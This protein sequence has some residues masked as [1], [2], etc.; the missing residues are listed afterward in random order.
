M[1]RVHDRGAG[2]A[3]G[4][5]P[6]ASARFRVAVRVGAQLREGDG[7]RLCLTASWTPEAYYWANGAAIVFDTVAALHVHVNGF[8]RLIAHVTYP[9]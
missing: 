2:Q 1:G 8:W 6:Q 9:D 7:W 5:E 4:P 3:E